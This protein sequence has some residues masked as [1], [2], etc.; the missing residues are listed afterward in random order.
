MFLENDLVDLFNNKYKPSSFI[1]FVLCWIFKSITLLDDKFT[2]FLYVLKYFL[3]ILI[4]DFCNLIFLYPIIFN[5]LVYENHNLLLSVN[6]R[7]ILK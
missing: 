7:Y 4:R 5:I 2:I 1:I 6:I 3:S